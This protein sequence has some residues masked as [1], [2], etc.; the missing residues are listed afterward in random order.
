MELTVQFL[1]QQGETQKISRENDFETKSAFLRNLI[2]K[3][4]FFAFSK[5]LKVIMVFFF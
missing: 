3:M 2:Y 5:S 4:Q 1:A